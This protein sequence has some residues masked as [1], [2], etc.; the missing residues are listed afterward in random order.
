MALN[1]SPSL[2]TKK[3]QLRKSWIIVLGATGL[4]MVLLAGGR[5]F[6]RDRP[7]PVPAA[8]SSSQELSTLGKLQLQPRPI[9]T[10]VI[11]I[12]MRTGGLRLL[13]TPADDRG[14]DL[15]LR[16][17][18]TSEFLREFDV[19]IAI[20]GDGFSHGGRAGS[21]TTILT[22]VIPSARVAMRPHAAGSTGR[23]RIPFRPC[24]STR[25]TSSASMRRRNHTMQSPER[26]C[27]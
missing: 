17:R 12:D 10:H 22:Q 8:S 25:G 27:W 13:V 15:P 7:I 3:R 4:A 20:N 21:L 1:L 11:T 5:L 19:Q 9:I 23:P 26:P 16:A 6:V 18:T 2:R 24:T 14:S